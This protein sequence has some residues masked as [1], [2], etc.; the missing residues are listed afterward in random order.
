VGDGFDVQLTGL[1]HL[2]LAGRRLRLPAIEARTRAACLLVGL[3]LGKIADRPVRTY[4]AGMRDRLDLAL[5]LIGGGSR[6]SLQPADDEDYAVVAMILADVT[7]A[8]PACVDGRFSVVLSDPAALWTV[9]ATLIDWDVP[10]KDLRVDQGHTV[11][12]TPL[13][14]EERGYAVPSSVRA[15]RALSA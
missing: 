8:E 10:I 6:L 12:R 5:S 1:E 11:A 3:G 14:G 2:L 4:S 9:I 13:I 7:G 15:G